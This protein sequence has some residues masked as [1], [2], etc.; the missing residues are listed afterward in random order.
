MK[1]RNNLYLLLLLVP[2][3]VFGLVFVFMT[4]HSKP[5]QAA[6]YEAPTVLG[7]ETQKQK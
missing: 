2:L 4:R 1:S 7:T 3:V 5:Q 6:V